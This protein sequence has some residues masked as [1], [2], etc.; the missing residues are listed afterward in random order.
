MKATSKKPGRKQKAAPSKTKRTKKPAKAPKSRVI[1]PPKADAKQAERDAITRDA[2]A[3]KSLPSSQLE[4][5]DQAIQRTRARP[6]RLGARVLP[7]KE[8][9]WELSPDFGSK[10]SHM[11]RQIDAFG[12]SSAAFAAY[13]ISWLAAL[14]RRRGGDIPSER[15]LNAALAVVDGVRPENEIEAMLAMQMYAAHDAA[16]EMMFQAKQA[17]ALEV[18]QGYSAIATKMMRTFIAQVEALNKLRK[19]G[20]Q[21]VRVEHVH[22]YPGGQAIVGAVTQHS[23]GGGSTQEN[24]GQPHGPNDPKALAFAPGAPVWRE[25]PGGNALP[26]TPDKR[27][28]TVPVP[29]RG[30]GKRGTNGRE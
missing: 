30:Q 16:M 24:L 3:D 17:P 6:A 12:T 19:G 18:T 9:G 14:A 28:D 25:E 20:E 1:V 2:D 23:Q 13:S 7:S 27:E 5:I 15:G 21:T 4:L 26:V 11:F 8:T 10:T 22:V 29:R